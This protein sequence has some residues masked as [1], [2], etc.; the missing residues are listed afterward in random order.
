MLFGG[1]YIVLLMGF[2]SIYTGLLYNDI[3]SIA[4]P[5]SVSGWSYNA[6]STGYFDPQKHFTYPFGIDQ[7]LLF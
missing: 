7:V 1:R 6:N 4:L 3:F 2:F 5:L